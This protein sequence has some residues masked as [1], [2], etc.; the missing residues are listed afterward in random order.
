MRPFPAVGPLALEILGVHDARAARQG[1]H[2]NLRAVQVGPEVGVV[3]DRIFRDHV[4][5]GRPAKRPRGDPAAVRRAGQ[6]LPGC[7]VFCGGRGSPGA[8]LRVEVGVEVGRVTLPWPRI[9]NMVRDA[10]ASTFVVTPIN[11][12]VVYRWLFTVM[13]VRPDRTTLTG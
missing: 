3:V 7:R 9:S 6:V 11:R 2:R 1:S 12:N 13:S 10:D 8:G 5:G 4:P